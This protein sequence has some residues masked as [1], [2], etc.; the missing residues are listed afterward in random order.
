LLL[1]AGLGWGVV[2]AV[3]VG[4]MATLPFAVAILVRAGR[5]AR[6]ATLPL[7]PFLVFGGLFV[8]LAP[9]LT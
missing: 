2:G 5:S 8:L 4:F 6:N 7:G 9:R 1:G 3:L